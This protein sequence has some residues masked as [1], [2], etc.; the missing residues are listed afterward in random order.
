MRTLVDERLAG[1]THLRAWDGRTDSG[2]RAAA[3]IYFVR[4]VAGEYRGARKVVLVR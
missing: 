1:G 3:G 4:M 2:E